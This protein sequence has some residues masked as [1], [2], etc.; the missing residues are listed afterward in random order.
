MWFKV[1]KPAYKAVNLKH[2][3]GFDFDP[4]KKTK[5]KII[6]ESKAEIEFLPQFQPTYLTLGRGQ[7]AAR[8][9]FYERRFLGKLFQRVIKNIGDTFEIQNLVGTFNFIR[10][11]L[12][13]AEI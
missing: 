8:E 3:D 5:E 11:S 7:K 1:S 9:I 13:K 6:R 4:S 12:T 2:V 10:K